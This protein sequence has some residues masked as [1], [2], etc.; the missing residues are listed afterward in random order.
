VRFTPTDMNL[1]DVLTKAVPTA[2]FERLV[3][4]CLNSKRGIL[5]QSGRREGELRVGWENL[6]GD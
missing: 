2:N 6:D 3:K 1:A 5:C 4:L